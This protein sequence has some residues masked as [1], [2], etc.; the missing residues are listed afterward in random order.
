MSR[1]HL[2]QS[3]GVMIVTRLHLPQSRGVM[4]VSRLHLSQG[5]K[6]DVKHHCDNISDVQF[7]HSGTCGVTLLSHHDSAGG[8]GMT[9]SSHRV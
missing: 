4:I 1:L 8:A 2:P 3:R 5:V 6:R 7:L 9:L